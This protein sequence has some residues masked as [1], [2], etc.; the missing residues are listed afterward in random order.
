MFSDPQSVTVNTVAQSMPR[1]SSDGRKA[2]YQKSDGTYTLTISH[3]K[4][5]TRTRSN[6]RIDRKAIVTNPLDSSNDYDTLTVYIVIDRPEFGF[7]VTDVQQLVAGFAAYL[8]N[9]AVAKVYG[10]ES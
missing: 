8:D 5:G 4:S 7:S 6:V 2:I 1:I 9:T 3:A 10:Q